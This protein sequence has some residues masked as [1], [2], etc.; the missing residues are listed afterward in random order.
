MAMI[1]PE[2][3]RRFSYF[4][5]LGEESLKKVAMI[6][7]ERNYGAEQVLFREDEP[8][9]TLFIVVRGEVDIQSGP[10]IR[11]RVNVDTLVEGDLMTWSALVR[12]HRTRF[13]GVARVDSQ[14]IAIQAALLRELL[15]ED[16]RLGYGVM[17]GVAEA[18][19]NR[20]AGARIQ[21]AH[22]GT[23]VE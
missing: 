4:A 22:A 18:I 23:T 20:L 5:G 15:E 1:S 19:S 14:V 8:A 12:P 3:L 7:E 16:P 11:S 2:Q 21:L 13:W 17:R 10:D 9:E 6:S